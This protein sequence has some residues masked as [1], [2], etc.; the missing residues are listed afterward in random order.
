[1][2]EEMRKQGLTQILR[3]GAGRLMNTAAGAAQMMSVAAGAVAGFA[4]QLVPAQD[5]NA[6]TGGPAP[7]PMGPPPLTGGIPPPPIG[8]GYSFQQQAPPLPMPSHVGYYEDPEHLFTQEQMAQQAQPM[9]PVP[10]MPTLQWQPEP[11]EHMA[12]QGAM[13]LQGQQQQ[14]LEED[15]EEVWDAGSEMFDFYIPDSIQSPNPLIQQQVLNT[16]DLLLDNDDDTWDEFNRNVRQ[17]ST[18]QGQSIKNWLSELRRLIEQPGID[19]TQHSTHGLVFDYYLL[20]AIYNSIKR[21]YPDI[22]L[23]TLRGVLLGRR[24]TASSSAGPMVPQSRG[25][26]RPRTIEPYPEPIGPRGR[27][28]PPKK[29]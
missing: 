15:I 22:T 14:S 1:M 12:A 2:A 27:R 28:K 26:G 25:P 11:F 4:G 5:P 3:Q 21:S 9:Q 8:Q 13:P 17:W 10:M 20:V 7:P 18:R 23:N 29:Q 24:S 16:M 19:F 6:L